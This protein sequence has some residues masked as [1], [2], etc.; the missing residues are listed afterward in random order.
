M[1]LHYL[2]DTNTPCEYNI[3]PPIQ[4]SSTISENNLELKQTTGIHFQSKHKHRDVFG[5]SHILYHDFDNG[6][7]FTFKDKYTV[8]LEQELQNSY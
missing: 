2:L 3:T 6:D 8:L 4:T 1:H 7:A 5:D